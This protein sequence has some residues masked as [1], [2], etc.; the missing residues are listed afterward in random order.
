MTNKEL[1]STMANVL[2]SKFDEL[3]NEIAGRDYV[4]LIKREI[5]CIEFYVGTDRFVL[6]AAMNVNGLTSSIN[7]NTFHLEREE[8]PSNWT[9]RYIPQLDV[10][11][12]LGGDSEFLKEQT[13]TINKGDLREHTYKTKILTKFSEEY[14]DLIEN[15]ITP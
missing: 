8:N 5:D 15:I 13:I 4:V 1:L 9:K 14:L 7:L 12:H 2:T 6:T 11:V 3:V 10:R